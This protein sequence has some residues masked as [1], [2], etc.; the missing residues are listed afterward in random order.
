MN[1]IKE[2]SRIT[3]VS[4]RT[5]H[6][7]DSIGLL[8]PARV[9]ESGYRLY[10]EASLER[11]QHIL[12]FKE[13][14]FPLKKI[15]QILDSP[16]FERNLALE[17]QL[18]LLLL[19]KEHL[20]NL[21][22]MTRGIRMTGVK[23]LDFSAFDAKK[24]DEYAA[25]AKTAWGKSAAYRE[26]EEKMKNR[27]EEDCT[28]INQ[29]F[30]ELFSEFGRLNALSILPDSDEAQSLVEQL[31]QFIT[32]NF[33]SCTP[34]LLQSLGKMYGGGGGFTESIDK[35]GGRGTADFTSKAIDIYADKHSCG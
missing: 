10:D 22:D 18:N 20:E 4:P 27:S 7:Y 21:I 24:I 34:E 31:L 26:Y 17:Q 3:G 16:D 9:T 30:M 1:T 6:Y 13:L 23:N 12:L 5:L 28:S 29:S 35:K 33:Y 8:K 25:Q 15:K 11:L 19:Q 32:E 14:R 2:V